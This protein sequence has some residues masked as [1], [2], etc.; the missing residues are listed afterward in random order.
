MLTYPKIKPHN[1]KRFFKWL[2]ACLAPHD[3]VNE[4]SDDWYD[5]QW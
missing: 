1:M 5:R 4:T 2:R 3:F